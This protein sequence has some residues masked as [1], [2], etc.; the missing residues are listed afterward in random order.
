M[1]ETFI[2]DV[3]LPVSG[4]WTTGDKWATLDSILANEF[5]VLRHVLLK[6]P[7]PLSSSVSDEL[8]GKYL[9]QLS[10]NA[11]VTWTLSSE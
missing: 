2:L 3:Q 10:K 4:W 11:M 9:P 6:N 5:P 8:S 1:I 7:I